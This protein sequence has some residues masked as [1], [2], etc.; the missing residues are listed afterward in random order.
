MLLPHQRLPAGVAGIKESSLESVGR[1]A[2]LTAGEVDWEAP[3]AE[4]DG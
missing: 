1:R 4:E 2:D 3:A